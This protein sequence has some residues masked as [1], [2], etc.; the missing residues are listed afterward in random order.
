MVQLSHPYMTI[1]KT[2]ALTIWT[3]VGKIMSLLFN[4]LSRFITAFPRNKY[5][6]IS[7][8]QSQSTVILEIQKINCHCFHCFPIYLTWSYRAWCHDL[9][10]LNVEFLS[11]LFPLFSFTLIKRLFNFSFLSA[12]KWCLLHIWGYWYFYR[13][14]LFQLVLHPAQHFTW[15]TLHIS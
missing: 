7:W 8:L 5:F 10:F 1:G 6:L 12:I 2:T 11:Q 4:M 13:Q 9:H 14:S 15:C 3:F